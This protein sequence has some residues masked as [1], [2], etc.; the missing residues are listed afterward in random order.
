MAFWPF[1]KRTPRQ[2]KDTSTIESESIA[3]GHQR[4]DSTISQAG[5]VPQRKRSKKRRTGKRRNSSQSSL[6]EDARENVRDNKHLEAIMPLSPMGSSFIRPPTRGSQHSGEDNITALPQSRKLRTSPHLRPATR[7]DA[8]IPYDFRL[9]DSSRVATPIPQS[10]AGTPSIR[11]RL[12]RSPSRR[13]YNP[14]SEK[15]VKLTKAKLK[16]LPKRQKHVREEDFRAMSAPTHVPRRPGTEDTGILRRESQRMREGLNRKFQRPMSD[17]SL[18]RPDTSR[19]ST[20]R[21]DIGDGGRNYRISVFDV[22]SPRPIIRAQ[23]QPYSMLAIGWS[24]PPSRANS[25]RWSARQTVSSRAGG[26][27]PFVPTRLKRVED[28]A[29]ELDSGDIRA[30]MERDKQRKEEKHA[31]D[32]EKLRRRLERRAARDE[33]EEQEQAEAGATGKELKPTRSRSH[34]SQRSRK[35]RV[36]REKAARAKDAS[37][38]REVAIEVL[39]KE[40]AEPTEM[41]KSPAIPPQSPLREKKKKKNDADIPAPLRIRTG[42]VEMDAPNVPTRASRAPIPALEDTVAGA[43][44]PTTRDQ[45]DTDYEIPQLP[46][47]GSSASDAETPLPSP[48]SSSYPLKQKLEAG[49]QFQRT[50]LIE[51]LPPTVPI[52][53]TP[54]VTALPTLAIPASPEKKK[55]RPSLLFS[56]FRRGEKK[57]Q[58]QR[59]L[60]DSSSLNRSETATSFV[61]ISRDHTRSDLSPIPGSQADLPAPGFSAPTNFRSRTPTRSHS[62]FVE[63]LPELNIARLQSSHRPL[64]PPSSRVNS[65]TQNIPSSPEFLRNNMITPISHHR[66]SDKSALVPDAND[67]E[68][69]SNKNP[70]RQQHPFTQSLASI[71]SEGSWLAGKPVK[72]M[73]SNKSATGLT[74]EPNHESDSEYEEGDLTPKARHSFSSYGDAIP[75]EEFNHRLTTTKLTGETVL[76]VLDRKEGLASKRSRGASIFNK[77]TPIEVETKGGRMKVHGDLAK[78]ASIQRGLRVRSSEGLLKEMLNTKTDD[79]AEREL[80]VDSNDKVTKSQTPADRHDSS[81]PN[82]ADLALEMDSSDDSN[83]GLKRARSVETGKLLEKDA[84]MIDVPRNVSKTSTIQH[85][86]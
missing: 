82:A 13:R 56:F 2:G 28:L 38:E 69:Q 72:R 40:K 31:S 9:Y 81:I 17:I 48:I 52:S 59:A 22:L 6:V 14:A 71:D 37:P 33:L 8:D 3:A 16:E 21:S 18:P 42:K 46:L 7:N 58:R 47:I 11:N 34:R 1:K 68:D 35:S 79:G 62:R 29:D 51:E 4:G 67:Q 20:R 84:K 39:Q 36:K 41:S 54:S 73:L 30:I 86:Q 24:A 50:D 61:N 27:Q 32:A 12:S 44:R 23:E 5:T 55:R 63:N 15:P 26:K 66:M 43:E 57:T 45:D 49:T 76:A 53:A 85:T 77:Q 19:P 25:G 10:R 70:S 64:S 60:S 83:L 78:Q 65:P 75:E 74:L 80:E